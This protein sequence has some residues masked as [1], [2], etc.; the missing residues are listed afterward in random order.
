MI[1]LVCVPL[2]LH[3][4]NLS[5]RGG[6]FVVLLAPFLSVSI[7]ISIFSL[8]AREVMSGFLFLV[9]ERFFSLSSLSPF[10]WLRERETLFCQV[11]VKMNFISCR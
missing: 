3:P 4:V 8:A 1:P 11:T 6:S 10:A 2:L 7:K 9:R 5:Q